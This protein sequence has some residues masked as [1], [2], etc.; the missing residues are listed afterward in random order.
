FAS[1]MVANAW[2]PGSGSQDLHTLRHPEQWSPARRDAVFDCFDA[3]LQKNVFAHCGGST[4]A[5]VKNPA[6]GKLVPYLAARYPGA[7]FLYLLR[8]PRRAIPSRLSMVQAIWRL[9]DPAAHL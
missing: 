3:C 6:F 9:S 7:R 4:W 5:V 1:S 2:P 8:D